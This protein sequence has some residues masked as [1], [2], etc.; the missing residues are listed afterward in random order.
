MRRVPVGWYRNTTRTIPLSRIKRREIKHEYNAQKV[1]SVTVHVRP[2]EL[3][4]CRRPVPLHARHRRKLGFR[5]VF[6]FQRDRRRRSGSAG[7]SEH[8][9]RC[10]PRGSET[11]SCTLTRVSL[12]LPRRRWRSHCERHSRLANSRPPSF[13]AAIARRAYPESRSRG[14]NRPPIRDALHGTLSYRK[15]RPS[16]LSS[17][18]SMFV[19]VIGAKESDA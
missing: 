2:Y 9:F 17:R 12:P 16:L 10:P 11:T 18:C 3:G 1:K 8:N 4:C 7:F 14:A 6:A 15:S 5:R 19:N 13:R